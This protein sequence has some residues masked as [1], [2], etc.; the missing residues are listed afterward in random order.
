[1]QLLIH[2]V[3]HKASIAEAITAGSP[4]DIGKHIA[5]PAVL[6][7]VDNPAAILERFVDHLITHILPHEV[8]V[9]YQVLWA[10]RVL[11]SVSVCVC[12]RVCVWR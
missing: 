3:Q 1:M 12:V 7:G 9:G 2:Q 5:S 10:L 6:Q 11:M 4:S 8:G